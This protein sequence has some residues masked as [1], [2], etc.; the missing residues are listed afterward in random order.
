MELRAS[1]LERQKF[2]AIDLP[3]GRLERRRCGLRKRLGDELFAEFLEYRVRF[4][5]APGADL[6]EGFYRLVGASAEMTRVMLEGRLGYYDA[7][8]PIVAEALAAVPH[9]TVLDLGCHAGLVPI[10]L[11]ARFPKARVVGVEGQRG[12]VVGDALAN[13]LKKAGFTVT[14][15]FYINDAGNQVGALAWAA[16]WLHQ[17]KTP[18][19]VAA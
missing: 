13:L 17:R 9:A 10:Y 7:A 4:N 5:A 11:G 1:L 14:K 15:E 6:S 12:A 16:Y 3:F 19:E 8:L 2:R 18:T